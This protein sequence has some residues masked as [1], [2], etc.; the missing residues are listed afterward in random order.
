[1]RFVRKMGISCGLVH[2][3]MK[4]NWFYEISICNRDWELRCDTRN[5][6]TD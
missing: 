3:E 2:F 6:N 1:M 4:C 5:E